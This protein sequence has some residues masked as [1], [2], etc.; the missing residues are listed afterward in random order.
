MRQRLSRLATIAVFTAG[1]STLF[2]FERL[3]SALSFIGLPSASAASATADGLDDDP[4]AASTGIAKATSARVLTLP[5][6]GSTSSNR[7]R[8]DPGW[9]PRPMVNETFPSW[10]DLAGA[11]RVSLR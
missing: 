9:T 11:T 2:L 7:M 4:T 3:V 5:D 1:T 8:Y 10:D 6:T